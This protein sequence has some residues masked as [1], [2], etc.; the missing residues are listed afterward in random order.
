M[1]ADVGQSLP[2]MFRRIYTGCARSAQKL[3]GDNFISNMYT[4]GGPLP[5]PFDK[6]KLIL[7]S[8]SFRFAGEFTRAKKKISSVFELEAYSAGRQIRSHCSRSVDGYTIG[9]NNTQVEIHTEKM[10]RFRR[11]RPTQGYTHTCDWSRGP[12]L[13][14]IANSATKVEP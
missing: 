4:A 6:H 13:H 8:F 2:P 1:T 3:L 10:L 14:G 9:V 5:G 12:F 11:L 7:L